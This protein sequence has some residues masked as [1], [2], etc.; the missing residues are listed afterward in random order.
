MS[1][2]FYKKDEWAIRKDTLI[3][4][5]DDW[6][7]VDL[8]DNPVTGILENFYYFKEGDERNNVYLENGKRP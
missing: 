5:P 8:D 1:D 6:L 3:G 7:Y 4:D 2:K